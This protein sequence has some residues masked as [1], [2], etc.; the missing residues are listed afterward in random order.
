MKTKIKDK[1]TGICKICGKETNVLPEGVC[2]SCIMESTMIDCLDNIEYDKDDESRFIEE[3][4][5]G[6]INEDLGRMSL[7]CG[8][9]KKFT[10]YKE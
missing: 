1:V 7:G 5:P 10:K 3:Q 9:F 6:Y 8:G 2:V 4:T